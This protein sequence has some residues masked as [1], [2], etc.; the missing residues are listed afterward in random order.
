M[1]IRP[2]H[3]VTDSGLALILFDFADSSARAMVQRTHGNADLLACADVQTFGHS[4]VSLWLI[5]M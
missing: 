2:N 4:D 3:I 1:D 5:R